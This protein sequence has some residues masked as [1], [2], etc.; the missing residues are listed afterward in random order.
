MFAVIDLVDG[1]GLIVLYLL[2]VEE[3]EYV[4]L[5]VVCQDSLRNVPAPFLSPVEEN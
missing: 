2:G 5:V 4:A 1:N 3:V